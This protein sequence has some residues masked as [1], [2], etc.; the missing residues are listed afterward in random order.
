V[1]TTTA[2]HIPTTTAITIDGN[3][4]TLHLALFSHQSR[5]RQ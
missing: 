2:H 3:A 4:E 5:I 1:A